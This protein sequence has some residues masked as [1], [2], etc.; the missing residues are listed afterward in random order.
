MSGD[1][2]RRAEDGEAG[3]ADG[4]HGEHGPWG[5]S[6]PW[7]TADPGTGPQVLPDSSGPQI[8]ISGGT[9]GTPIVSDGTGG[10]PIIGGGTGGHPVVADGSGAFP[11]PPNGTGPLPPLPGPVA[12]SA[13]GPRLLLALGGLLV[14]GVV[15]AAG[16]FALRSEGGGEQNARV[17]GLPASKKVIEAGGTAGGLHRDALVG[18]AASAAYPFVAGA[19]EAGGVPAAKRGQAV[20]SEEPVRRVN[21]LFVGGTGRVGS[22]AD[23]LQKAQPTTFIAGQDADP[24]P[25]GGRAACGTFAVLA[26]THTYCAWATGDSYG[27]VASNVPSVNPEFTLMADVMRRIRKDVE[28]PR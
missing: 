11:A 7:W 21:V 25:Q 19:V 1:D 4:E 14:A 28:R 20:Y 9:G 2:P 3:G 17:T 22:P 15:V 18:P 27:I 26:Q 6:R 10:H 16:V 8:V 12:G 24:G 13:R 5:G 23:F